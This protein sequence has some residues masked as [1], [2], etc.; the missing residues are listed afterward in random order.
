MRENR[1]LRLRWRVLE[2]GSFGAPRQ[3][4]TLLRQTNQFDQRLWSGIKT[5]ADASSYRPAEMSC[6]VISI[7]LI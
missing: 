1:P 7:L 2:T 6:E 4:S 5:A 3:H